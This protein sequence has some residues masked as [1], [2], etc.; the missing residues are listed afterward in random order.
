MLQECKL[1]FDQKADAEEPIAPEKALLAYH[2]HGILCGG[3]SW[4]G[5]HAPELKDIDM[6]MLIA[7]GL[8]DMPIFGIVLRW[9]GHFAKASKEEIKRL[10]STGKVLAIIP[11]GFEEAT[12]STR[13]KDAVYLKKRRDNTR[14]LSI[15]AY[16]AFS[17]A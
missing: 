17:N 2:P 10:M 3:F 11:G 13:G 5:A 14:A 16:R 1:H 12:I 9:L 15:L 8:Y 7:S 6:R 4:N